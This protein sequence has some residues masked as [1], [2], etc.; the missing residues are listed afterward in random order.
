MSNSSCRSC[1]LACQRRWISSGASS[2]REAGF[3]VRDCAALDLAV[4]WSAGHLG[5]VKGSTNRCILSMEGKRAP[6]VNPGMIFCT[7]GSLP[8]SATQPVFH[9]DPSHLQSSLA[10]PWAPT[11]QL[12]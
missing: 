9:S 5:K 11:Q 10:T 1:S 12:S 3:R 2:F 6:D 4:A 7:A 8:G